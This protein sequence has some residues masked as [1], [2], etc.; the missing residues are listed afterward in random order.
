M[1]KIVDMSEGQCHW[2]TRRL[3][4]GLLHAN[5]WRY[6]VTKRAFVPRSQPYIL[7]FISMQESGTRADKDNTSE[8]N[9][10]DNHLAI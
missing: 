8:V 4:F 5:I 10:R 1:G 2:T 9:F 7:R 3:K 6:E